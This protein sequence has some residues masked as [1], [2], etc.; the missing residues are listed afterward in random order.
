MIWL[1]KC[2]SSGARFL[3]VDVG[4]VLCLRNSVILYD[5]IED[6]AVTV[7]GDATKLVRQSSS[8]RQTIQGVTTDNVATVA[9]SYETGP[10]RNGSLAEA[11]VVANRRDGT[12]TAAYHIEAGVARAGSTLNYDNQ[13]AK[14]HGRRNADRADVRRH[15]A[16][17]R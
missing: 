10:R 3:G 1:G 11:K 7:G 12:E 5:C 16:D 13:T 9:W 6:A 17:H 2:C 8:A 15:R 14:L 4:A